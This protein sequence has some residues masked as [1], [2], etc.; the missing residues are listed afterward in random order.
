[1]NKI[2]IISI[3]LAFICF[4][5]AKISSNSS[6]QDISQ[7]KTI[8]DYELRLENNQIIKL[9][10]FKGKKILIVNTATECG[11]TSQLESL[12]E[13]HENFKKDLVIIGTPSNDFMNQE[14]RSNKEIINFCKLNYG[15]E[16]LIT[17]KIHVKGKNK[18]PIYEFLTNKIL[19]GI[20]DK[21]VSWNFNKFLIDEEGYLLKYFGSMTKPLSKSITSLI[22]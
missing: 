2:V 4:V 6:D 14:P 17:E 20:N 8:Y 21:N 9:K 22:K 19:N 18:H 12:Q 5:Y 11:F 7:I 10:N 1:M 15:V 13:L 3:I 16:F